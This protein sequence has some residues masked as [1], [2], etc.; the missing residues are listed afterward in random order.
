ME[1][2]TNFFCAEARDTVQHPIKPR[3]A[4][5]QGAGSNSATNLPFSPAWIEFIHMDMHLLFTAICPGLRKY[6]E[7][8][9]Y[10]LPVCILSE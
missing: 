8:S 1:A 5:R 4:S 2:V 3:A 10:I 9:R 6:Q 7:Y